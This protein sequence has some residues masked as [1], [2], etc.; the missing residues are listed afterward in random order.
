MCR[1]LS[2]FHCKRI[3]ALHVKVIWLCPLLYHRI[4]MESHVVKTCVCGFH[5]YHI[6]WTK[7]HQNQLGSRVKWYRKILT[8]FKFSGL[9]KI[10]QFTK[11]HSSPIFVLIRYAVSCAMPPIHCYNSDYFIRML[12]A[13][14]FKILPQVLLSLVSCS[15][16][17]DRRWNKIFHWPGVCW[18]VTV[19][20]HFN[21]A[22]YDVQK[23]TNK[24]A[25]YTSLQKII[26]Y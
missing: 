21:I 12:C 20:A 17:F 9:V 24:E 3:S 2:W 19:L 4:Q 26:T 5:V 11:F 16:T 1:S 14:N 8:R 10:C 15:Q 7:C 13:D 6:I 22:T 25:A 23:F 18:L